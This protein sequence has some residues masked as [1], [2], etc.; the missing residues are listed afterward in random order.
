[1]TFRAGW[2]SL[3]APSNQR[4]RPLSQFV[5]HRP[6]APLD[7]VVECLWWS[8]RDEP[9]TVHEH[10]LPAGTAQLIVALHDTPI[11][12]RPRSA[13]A[14]PMVWSGGI[15]HGPQ[16]HHYVS[17]PKPRGA[18]VGVSFRAG[19]AGAVLGVPIGELTDRHVTV[20]ALWGAQGRELRERLMA[21]ANPASMFRILEG[22]LT[23]R[24]RWPLLLHPAV[25]HALM[26]RPAWPSA[27]VTDIQR[28]SGYSPRHFI[29]LF[30]EAVG[31]TPKHYFRIRRFTTVLQRLAGAGTTK[32]AD[33]AAQAGYADQA[34][35]T[36]EF[37]DFAGIT[38]TLYRPMSPDGLLHHRLPAEPPPGK[39]PSR[40]VHPGRRTLPRQAARPGG[41]RNRR[42]P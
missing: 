21:A 39:K 30:R 4:D 38:P 2:R 9:Q 41:H 15:V 14:A 8:Q 6:S 32:L 11:L 5:R 23:A 19:A 26:P 7:A 22:E 1:M 31:L 16:W 18:V 13:S 42:L 12:C 27:R 28:R 34:H 10:M 36:R 37:R 29:A 24:L 20:D 17:G 35:L 40:P 3:K 33:L 25:A